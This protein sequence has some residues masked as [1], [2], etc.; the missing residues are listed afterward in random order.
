LS[1]HRRPDVGRPP[2]SP[3]LYPLVPPTQGAV[4]TAHLGPPA[5][6]ERGLRPR[7]PLPNP[8]G[9]HRGERRYAPPYVDQWAAGA[10]GESM[11]TCLMLSRILWI[12]RR[13]GRKSTAPASFRSYTFLPSR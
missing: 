5:H 13:A 9:G 8:V 11:K 1:P 7:N 3:V 6:S 12:S 4:A 10:G 2:A